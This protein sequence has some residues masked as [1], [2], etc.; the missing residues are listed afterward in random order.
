MKEEEEKIEEIVPL[1]P[2]LTIRL[3]PKLK[4]QLTN[5]LLD[6]YDET[7]KWPLL[8]D[9]TYVLCFTFSI[10]L[11]LT[12]SH[13]YAV[14]ASTLSDV[15]SNKS[16]FGTRLMWRCPSKPEQVSKVEENQGVLSWK[17]VVSKGGSVLYVVFM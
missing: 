11:F 14:C 8:P 17:G 10:H 6:I 9:R 16:P 5:R 12:D 2:S 15:M 4:V 7:S 3:C 1:E 13:R